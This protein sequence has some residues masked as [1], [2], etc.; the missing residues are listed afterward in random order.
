MKRV[1]HNK[2]LVA[3]WNSFRDRYLIPFDLISTPIN[4]LEISS[5]YVSNNFPQ[6]PLMVSELLYRGGITKIRLFK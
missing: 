4:H 5:R 1:N 2:V 6:P 3:S